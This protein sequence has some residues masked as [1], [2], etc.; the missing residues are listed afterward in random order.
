MRIE[1]CFE[2]FTNAALKYNPYYKHVP[3]SIRESNQKDYL[4]CDIARVLGNKTHKSIKK[5]ADIIVS[6]LPF[7]VEVLDNGD[8]KF[9]LWQEVRR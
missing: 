8:I 9:N 7:I 3:F 5:I 1:E 6:D 2:L 4:L